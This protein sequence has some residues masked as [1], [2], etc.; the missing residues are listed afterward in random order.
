MD[1]NAVLHVRAERTEE[2]HYGSEEGEGEKLGCL[3]NK[4][5]IWIILRVHLGTK[6]DTGNYIHSEAAETPAKQT[7]SLLIKA[8]E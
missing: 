1:I 4:R 3:V 6:R 5:V 2:N 7:F 8:L